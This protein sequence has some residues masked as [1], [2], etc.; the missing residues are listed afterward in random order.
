MSGIVAIIT[1]TIAIIISGILTNNY[2]FR[3]NYETQP[4]K[5]INKKNSNSLKFSLVGLPNIIFI[6][7]IFY[8]SN[9]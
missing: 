3:N 1:F 4:Q 6:F 5:K 7:I 2:Q 8:L 9:N